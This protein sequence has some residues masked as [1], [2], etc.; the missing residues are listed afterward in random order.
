MEL[1][2]IL[3]KSLLE[4]EDFFFSLDRYS[5]LFLKFQTSPS[6]GAGQNTGQQMMPSQEDDRTTGRFYR[7]QKKGKEKNKVLNP[8]H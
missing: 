1:Y 8:L 5:C 7:N 4:K 3:F 6:E 2:Y